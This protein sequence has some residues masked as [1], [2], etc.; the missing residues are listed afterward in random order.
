MSKSHFKTSVTVIVRQNSRNTMLCI[1]CVLDTTID[2]TINITLIIII[3][4]TVKVSQG[5]AVASTQ[6]AKERIVIMPTTVITN[7]ALISMAV[8]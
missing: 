5:M 7:A 4:T 8:T 1:H 6:F 3:N 2:G